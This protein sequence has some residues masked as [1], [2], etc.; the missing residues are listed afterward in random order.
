MFKLSNDQDILFQIQRYIF[1]LFHVDD[2][3]PASSKSADKD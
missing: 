1:E 2:L 3:F